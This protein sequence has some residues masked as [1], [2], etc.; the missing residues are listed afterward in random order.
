MI[1]TS[2]VR[3]I[4]ALSSGAA[5]VRW[6]QNN[7]KNEFEQNE[8]YQRLNSLKKAGFV[9]SVL[10]ND[11]SGN[12]KSYA[13]YVLTEHGAGFLVREKAYEME[14]IRTAIP[15]V[16]TVAHEL[17]VTDVVRTI[18]RESI[19][20]NYDLKYADEALVKKMH[21][22]WKIKGP[23]PDLLV[24]IDLSR[25]GRPDVRTFAVEVDMGTQLKVSI[26][27]K[28]EKMQYRTLMLCSRKPRIDKL[29]IAFAPHEK[30]HS[31]IAFA[32]LHDFCTRRGGLI[33]TDFITPDGRKFQIR[34][35]KN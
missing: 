12:G 20:L 4:E 6:L 29:M 2:D 3:I 13:L 8:L 28:V 32:N 9:E 31:K 24:V 23:Q 15:S 1:K 19:D 17:A 22:F 30:L 7:F 35:R 26:L 14:K 33:G 27:D 34:P 18:K 21:A 16:H 5:T 25:A 10:Y 11:F